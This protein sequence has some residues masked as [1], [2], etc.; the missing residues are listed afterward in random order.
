MVARIHRSLGSPSRR[1]LGAV[2]VAVVLGVALRL[3]VV[4]VTKGHVL[5]GDEIEYDIQGR[6]TAAGQWFWSTTPYGIPHPSLWKAPVYPGWVGLWYSVLGSGSYDRVLAVQ[7]VVLG[8]ATIGLTWLLGRRWLGPPVGVVAALIVAVYP[9]AFLGQVRLFSES[10]GVPLFLAVVLLVV[11]RKPSRGRVVAVGALMGVVLLTRPSWAFLFAGIAAAWV[12]AEGW[13]RGALATAATVAI[14]ALVV[15]PWTVRNHVVDGGWVPISVQDAAPY[16]T[17]ND[18]AANDE[19]YRWA[20]R[21]LTR[22]DADLFDPANPMSDHEL[23]ARLRE[24]AADYIREHPS[25]VPKATIY[26]GLI[27]TWDLRSPSSV[28]FEATTFQARPRPLVW[29]GVAGYYVLV[30]LTVV[31][32]W[33]LRQER[34]LLIPLAALVVAGTVTFTPV[35]TTRY[36]EPFEPLLAVL[37]ASTVVWLIGRIR[38]R[39]TRPAVG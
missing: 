25:S 32:V 13:R 20:W 14:A 10:V 5:N 9:F 11:G 38:Q 24:R 12:V 7:A 35:G 6:F 29:A 33:R 30:A 31:S 26:N 28:V 22:R 3:L 21:P 8:P 18:D 19:D 37:A 2:G 15:A 16:G 4:V 39:R 17:F 34:W 36:R 27:R 23:R 1:E